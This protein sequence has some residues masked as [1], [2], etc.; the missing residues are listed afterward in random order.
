MILRAII[1]CEPA[2]LTIRR[3]SEIVICASVVN[4]AAATGAKFHFNMRDRL[5]ERRGSAVR[6]PILLDAH[7]ASYWRA[8]RCDV[9]WC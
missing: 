9:G 7:L 8:I 1:D 6:D 5:P 3:K 4:Q 2:D